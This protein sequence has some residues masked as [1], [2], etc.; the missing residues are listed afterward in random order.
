MEFIDLTSYSNKLFLGAGGTK[1][2][3]LHDNKAI[4]L[5]NKVDGLSLRKIWDRSVND[6]ITMSEHLIQNNIPCLKPM[7]MK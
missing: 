5:P 6:E 3:I 4:A 1:T 2:I 7:I